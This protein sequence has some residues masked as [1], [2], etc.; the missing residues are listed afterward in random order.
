MLILF[1][2]PEP[3]T[4]GGTG[5]GAMGPTE[6]SRRPAKRAGD[7]KRAR[8]R[9]VYDL[10]E[11]MADVARR[12]ARERAIVAQAIEMAEIAVIAQALFIVD[13]L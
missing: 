3:A 1:W 5:G 2:R 9:A 12:E 4:V 13:D 8:S 6:H 11:T 10:G 7:G